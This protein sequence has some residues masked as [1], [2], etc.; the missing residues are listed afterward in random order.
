MLV[1]FYHILNNMTFESQAQKCCNI[2]TL[3]TISTLIQFE[4][5]IIRTNVLSELI[6]LKLDISICVHRAEL[7]NRA[8]LSLFGKK[9]EITK[10]SQINTIVW[11]STRLENYPF[12]IYKSNNLVLKIIYLLVVYPDI[13]IIHL[14]S[15]KISLL[16]KGRTLTAT[17]TDDIL[18]KQFLRILQTNYK[19]C[20]INKP[21]NPYE[22]NDDTSK[23]G[24]NW[25][26]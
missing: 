8:I 1:S 6:F 17:L 14:H 21:N 19:F 18:S 4:R 22:S 7:P 25:R 26:K 10:H 12:R 16:L 13:S 2:S 5:V 20:N 3:E 11:H 15:L 23:L 24:P 9:H